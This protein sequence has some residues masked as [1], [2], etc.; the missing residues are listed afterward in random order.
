M[1]MAENRTS[2]VGKKV[3]KMKDNDPEIQENSVKD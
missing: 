3:F 1:K 2:T